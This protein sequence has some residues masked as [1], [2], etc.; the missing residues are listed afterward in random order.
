[1]ILQYH[2]K[3]NSLSGNIYFNYF[4]FDVLV[5][6]H[7]FVYIGHITFFELRDMNQSAFFD[8]DID[9]ATEVGNIVHNSVYDH[10]DFYIVNGS[11][12]R[13]KLEDFGFFSRV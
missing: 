9:K 3:L 1:M 10:P 12:V 6:F 8:S 4:H 7:Y 5:E 13:V 2:R 11:E